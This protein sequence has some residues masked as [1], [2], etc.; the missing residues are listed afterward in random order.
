MTL[1]ADIGTGWRHNVNKQTVDITPKWVSSAR[2]C[3]LALEHGTEEGKI[4]ARAEIIRMGEILDAQ[5]NR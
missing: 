5:L 3:I 2:M 4:I 1:A